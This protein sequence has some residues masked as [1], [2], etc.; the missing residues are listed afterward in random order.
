M[1]RKPNPYIA[2]PPVSGRNFYGREDIFRFVQNTFSSPQ[3]NV[4]VLWGQRRMGKT[5]VLHVLTSR[6]SPEFHPIYFDLQDKA[7]QK[8][9]QVLYDLAREIAGS[10]NLDSPPR[11][12]FLHDD[13]YFHERFLS[14]VYQSLGSKRLL[15][16]FDELETVNVPP[17]EG[18]TERDVAY[19]A[20]FP[21]LRRRLVSNRRL[22][23]IFAMGRRLDEVDELILSTFEEA[24]AKSVSFLEET[25]A[26]RLVVEPASGVLEYD[27]EA[28]GR[29]ISITACHSYLTQ[30]ICFELFSYMDATGR[31]RVTVSDVEA[32]VDRAIAAGEAGL[33]WLW[34]G[35]PAAERFVLSAMAH[36]AKE[37][38]AATQDEIS[39]ILKEYRVSFSGPELT[40]ALNNLTRWELLRHTAD[41]YEFVVEL[42]RRWVLREHSLEQ[43]KR[44]LESVSPGAIV[45]YE[46]A[47]AYHEDGDYDKAIRRYHDAL[48]VNPN[49]I[50]ARLGLAQALFE[51]GKTEEAITE[52]ERAYTLD[53]ARAKDGLIEAWQA[54]SETLEKEGRV[55]EADQQYEAILSTAPHDPRVREWVAN[56]WT[57]RGRTYLTDDRYE[58]AV[59]EY[60]KAAELDVP[61]AWE[62]LIA[63]RHA[64]AEA[65]EREGRA[66]EAD[67]QY[68][69]ILSIAPDDDKL[70][71]WIAG[72][73]MARG[74]KYLGGE[75]Y[76]EAV[77]EY[78]KAVALDVP[79]AWEG[80]IA[81]RQAWAETLEK[82]CQVNEADQ[83]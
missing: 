70:K 2:G 20:F 36:V 52:F 80:L 40:Q 81:A 9:N 76:E 78:E 79:G 75:R 13:D 34:D 8:L 32:V 83:E 72:C 27:E 77:A 55:N 69:A 4:I 37:G 21:Y 19:R 67:Q 71:D 48:A 1:P 54:W 35:L 57:T 50:Q 28:I 65:L 74:Q 22:A 15:L 66:N 46:L 30:L 6:L 10:L 39:R 42:L 16:M 38:R 44:E 61:G 82:E 33:T 51:Q 49:H 3:Q 25:E 11:A 26:R 60:E 63:A 58:E 62:R 68:E 45:L 43:A 31:T 47:R 29:I 56:R 5:S 24:R 41:G 73:W 18:P 64:W 23:F 59:A 12:D 53:R 17:V 14:Q 7:Q